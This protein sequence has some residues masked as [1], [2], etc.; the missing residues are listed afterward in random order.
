MSGRPGDDERPTVL[1]V[2]D[3]PTDAELVLIAIQQAR[4]DV[5]VEVVNSGEAA[6]RYL[7]RDG[8]HVDAPT[9]ALVLLDFNL[10]GRSG[11][12]VLELV[13]SDEALRSIPIVMFSNS[14]AGSDVATAYRH[15]ANAY[16]LKPM[17]YA[18]IKESLTALLAF[19]LDWA[20]SPTADRVAP[21]A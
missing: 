1:L 13:K 19:W 12:E 21:P 11:I 4:S 3:S 6:L 5:A 7:Y 2:E 14:N 18:D 20:C 8:E 10:P 17:E 9:P 15:H 16:L